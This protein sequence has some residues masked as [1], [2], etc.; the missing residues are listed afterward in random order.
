MLTLYIYGLV[1]A[2][3]RI[4]IIKPSLNYFLYKYFDRKSKLL[5][6]GCGGGQVDIDLSKNLKITA[7]DIS[8]LALNQYKKNNPNVEKLIHG[9]IL[10]IPAKKS[11]YD[12]IYNLGVMEHFTKD[13]IMNIL[14][15]F[16][17]V[18]KPNG[19]IVLFWPPEFGL[20]V[21]FLKFAHFI[22]NKIF[23]K[24]IALHPDEISRIFAGY[25]RH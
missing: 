21:K 5:H 10:S 16:H 24:K 12:G 2:F 11:S 25:S 19:V 6:A 4:F 14:K 17:R 20:S 22:L 1:A 9:S 13:E 18:L 23:K 15:E 8:A 7:L 3:Y